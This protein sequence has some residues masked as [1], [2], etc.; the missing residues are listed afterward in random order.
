MKEHKCKGMIK[1]KL[2]F[3]SSFFDNDF[4]IF[5]NKLTISQKI[6]L[7]LGNFEIPMQPEITIKI[8]YCPFCAKKLE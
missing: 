1:D 4:K 2:L 7:N 8:K 3:S 5:D 6:Q